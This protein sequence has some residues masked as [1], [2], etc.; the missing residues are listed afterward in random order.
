MKK[1]NQTTILEEKK[2]RIAELKLNKYFQSLAKEI[3]NLANDTNNHHFIFWL[4]GF[5][6]RKGSFYLNRGK[7]EFC[8]EHS[9][10]PEL[11]QLIAEKLKAGKVNKLSYTKD[12]KTIIRTRL[13]FYSQKD[14]SL[15]ISILNSYIFEENKL[16]KFS[17]CLNAF[18]LNRKQKILLKKTNTSAFNSPSFFQAVFQGF[19]EAGHSPFGYY[20]NQLN[21][22]FFPYIAVYSNTNPYLM[23][24]FNKRLKNEKK[25]EKNPETAKGREALDNFNK[26]KIKDKSYIFFEGF[27]YQSELTAAQAIDKVIQSLNLNYFHGKTKK[28]FHN[29]LELNKEIKN[30]EKL[31]KSK[32]EKI[33]YSKLDKIMQFLQEHQPRQINKKN[34]NALFYSKPTTNLY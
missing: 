19:L 28:T 4:I 7:P 3:P 27:E 30:L 33:F 26:F 1:E 21:F 6:N 23:K 32:R 8:L 2:I 12:G 16:Q 31:D 5:F 17:E 13:A 9:E 10:D 22:N 25:T 15:L 34:K 24:L 18:N 14:F 20:Y 11:I 29:F